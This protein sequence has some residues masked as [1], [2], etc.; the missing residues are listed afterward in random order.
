[1]AQGSRRLASEA[2]SFTSREYKQTPGCGAADV[3]KHVFLF[4]M[5]SPPTIELGR[6]WGHD[7]SIAIWN[8]DLAAARQLASIRSD[9][10]SGYGNH[11]SL[12]LALRRA[13]IVK[14]FASF[15]KRVRLDDVENC[16]AVGDSDCL[17]AVL[18]GKDLRLSK[19]GTRAGDGM[20]LAFHILLI[21]VRKNKIAFVKEFLPSAAGEIN[22]AFTT[23]IVTAAGGK[24]E[25]GSTLLFEAAT[26]ASCAIVSM[27]VAAGADVHHFDFDGNTS[28]HAAALRGTKET[29]SFLISQGV[30]VDGQNSERYNA[31]DTALKN[32]NS[33]V[34]RTLI[35]E[36]RLQ[37]VAEL[38]ADHSNVVRRAF[39]DS[40]VEFVFGLLDCGFPFA[41]TRFE[42]A[43]DATQSSEFLSLLKTINHAPAKSSVPIVVTELAQ[44]WLQN[45]LSRHGMCK[46]TE[47][48]V[49]VLPTRILEISKQGSAC[50]LLESRGRRAYYCTLSHRWAGQNMYKTTRNNITQH[51]QDV[52]VSKMSQSIRLAIQLASTLGIKYLWV[53]AFCIVQDLEADKQTEILRMGDIFANSFLTIAIVDEAGKG[54]KRRRLSQTLEHDKR[55][56][57][58]LD[59]RAWVLQEQ[60]LSRRVLNYVQGDVFWDC[61]TCSASR[62]YPA[63]IP[64]N[65]DRNFKERDLRVLKEGIHLQ[66]LYT[67]NQPAEHYLQISWH[68][69]VEDYSRRH[70]TNL[71]DRALAI[72]GVATRISAVT[73]DE[74]LAGL[75]RGR[76]VED[77]CWSRDKRFDDDRIA[78]SRSFRAPSWSWLG[79]PYPIGYYSS[80]A[81]NWR[82]AGKDCFVSI[83]WDSP[84]IASGEVSG[85]LRLRGRMYG[86]K[87]VMDKAWAREARSD[88]RE[89]GSKTS[90]VQS[91]LHFDSDEPVDSELTV[92]HSPGMAL[93]LVLQQVERESRSGETDLETYRRVGTWRYHRGTIYT[94]YSLENELVEI[95]LI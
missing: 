1:M 37:P 23:S 14:Y 66:R 64:I 15:D 79:L 29:A 33:A 60:I 12:A 74:Y 76:I 13:D 32:N 81:N 93:S 31:L 26:H 84:Q 42:K 16:I 67:V 71:E 39:L 94:A 59:T 92:W 89:A 78:P 10:R 73:K 69:V 35:L 34:A 36:H 8:S 58:V 56:K 86:L 82:G 6:N 4:K 9:V 49:P 77:L 70:L 27:L 52:K 95:Y 87:D 44:E 72:A 65:L 53:D 41:D 91:L 24:I 48:E 2:A 7:L 90:Y 63:G 75:W 40:D 80:R 46:L 68:R 19:D 50:R 55:P 5:E 45:C 17:S 62:S 3:V 85:R 11:W 38:P 51:Y 47:A 30:A 28:L 21:A 18:H 83:S 57:G 22:T 20:S 54:K 88:K 61:L 43:V 25:A